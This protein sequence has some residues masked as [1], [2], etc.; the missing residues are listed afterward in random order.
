[1]VLQLH[2]AIK[3]LSRKGAVADRQGLI[4][5][6]DIRLHTGRDGEGQTHIHAAGIGFDGLID[7]GLNAGELD[8]FIGLLSNL[9]SAQT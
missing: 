1:M 3:G 8:D 9:C 7:E 2:D 5:D 6:Q 4:N